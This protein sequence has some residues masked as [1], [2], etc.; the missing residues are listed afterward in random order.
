M[1]RTPYVEDGDLEEFIYGEKDN[2]EEKT[3][4]SANIQQQKYVANEAPEGLKIS[5]RSSAVGAK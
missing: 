4:S 3:E 2:L 1:V 5:S